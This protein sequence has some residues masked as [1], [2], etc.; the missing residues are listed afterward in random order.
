MWGQFPEVPCDTKLAC[1]NGQIILE[2]FTPSLSDLL[3]TPPV[4]WIARPNA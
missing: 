1:T 4:K 3:P 2:Q